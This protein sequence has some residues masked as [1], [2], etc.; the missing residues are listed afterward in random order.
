METRDTVRREDLS[1]SKVDGM[2][3]ASAEVSSCNY[4]QSYHDGCSLAPLKPSLRLPGRRR[5]V[6][7]GFVL[8]AGYQ[9]AR[10]RMRPTARSRSRSRPVAPLKYVLALA[11]L[12]ERL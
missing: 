9:S 2:T 11:T 7:S 10:T 3:E 4:L 8:E 5:K 1:E 6:P 12:N